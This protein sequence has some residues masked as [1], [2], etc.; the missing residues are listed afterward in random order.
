MSNNKFSVFIPLFIGLALAVG[1]AIGYFFSGNNGSKKIAGIRNTS[2]NK[3]SDVLNYIIDEYVDTINVKSIEDDAVVSLLEQLDPHSSYIPATELQA[4]SEQLEGNFD[5]I[6]VEFN[7]QKDT[8]MVVAAISGGPSE[9]LGIQSGDR[10]VR[11]EKKNV[12]GT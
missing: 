9:S 12:A 1:V 5:G 2:S 6:G 10:I 3:I 7:I 11:V 4:V 8:I